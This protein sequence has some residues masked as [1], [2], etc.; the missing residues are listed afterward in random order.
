MDLFGNSGSDFPTGPE[1]G[2]GFRITY[3]HPAEIRDGR[4]IPEMQTG[5][6]GF[7]PDFQAMIDDLKW[8]WERKDFP[9]PI[10]IELRP[11]RRA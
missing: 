10:R 7:Y 2:I 11:T 4:E 3:H 5:S 8:M 6:G 9:L 1:P